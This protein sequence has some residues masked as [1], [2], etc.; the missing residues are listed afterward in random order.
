MELKDKGTNGSSEH[1]NNLSHE[2]F[3]YVTLTLWLR[4][5]GD[6]EKISRG[7]ISILTERLEACEAATGRGGTRNGLLRGTNRGVLHAAGHSKVVR[8]I[9]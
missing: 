6:S 5:N 2:Q 9:R 1:L 8:L 7:G 3:Y 4:T